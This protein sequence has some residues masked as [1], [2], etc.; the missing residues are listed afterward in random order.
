VIAVVRAHRRA[1]ALATIVAGLA[2]LTS[3]CKRDFGD[4]QVVRDAIARTERLARRFTYD[5]VLGSKK[6][7]V[8]GVVQDDFRYKARLV[9]GGAPILDEVANDDALADRIVDP[10]SLSL[11]EAP[12]GQTA[13]TPAVLTALS[14]QRWVLDP[15]GAP[16]LIPN[17]DDKRKQGDDPVFDALTALDYT[18]AAVEASAFV[19]QYQP[20]ALEPIY[21]PS[22]DPFP[23]PARG[24]STKRYD[25]KEQPLPSKNGVTQAGGQQVPTIEDFRKMA[26]YIRD[27]RVVEVQESIDVASK[28]PNL[29]RNFGLP[30]GTTVSEAIAGINS[31]RKGQ[32]SD[33]IRVRRMTLQFTDFNAGESADLPTDAVNGSLSV[34]RYRGR[35]VVA[36]STS[37]S[38]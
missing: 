22:E 1:I 37:G 11:L 19:K 9:V 26:V 21:R 10:A 8:R 3:A 14:T 7:E 16:S 6:T 29:I 36:A 31:V 17:A 18:R 25:L 13:A 32:G 23:K 15:V 35:Q 38:G 27:G 2:G 12:A 30:A 28:L 33:P 34:L 4:R 20:D 5:D 24:S